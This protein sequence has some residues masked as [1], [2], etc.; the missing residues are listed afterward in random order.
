MMLV[1][2]LRK[3]KSEKSET[4]SPK[5]FNTHET[6]RLWWLTKLNT[7]KFENFRRSQKFIHAKLNTFKVCQGNWKCDFNLCDC[8]C[9]EW[10][11][12]RLLLWGSYCVL[13]LQNDPNNK[14]RISSHSVI[15][16]VIVTFII[17]L[18]TF[19]IHFFIVNVVRT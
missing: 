7:H 12:F 5:K 8:F 15:L 10:L 1:W 17:G 9:W 19:R 16:V 4:F 2:K 6:L 18:S 13:N 3:N 11:L 14:T